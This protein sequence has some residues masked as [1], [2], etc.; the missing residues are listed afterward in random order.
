MFEIDKFEASDIDEER[1]LKLAEILFR[2]NHHG[3]I[4]N[5]EEYII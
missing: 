2:M 5:P 4:Y 3:R 1:D